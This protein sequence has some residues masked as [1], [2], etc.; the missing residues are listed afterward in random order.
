VS[1]T[2]TPR[3]LLIVALQ[4][5]HDGER[6]WTERGPKFRNL[7]GAELREF[8][9]ADLER[10][11]AQA[12]ELEAMLSSLDAVLAGDPN[13]WLR[14]ILDDADRDS[15][16]IVKGRLLDTALI[17]AFRKGKQAERVSYETAIVL[18]SELDLPVLAERLT[19]ICSQENM[20]DREL[21]RLLT[22]R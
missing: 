13:I 5:L 12:N 20:A 10:S 16:S 7:V 21:H 9:D 22:M 15:E 11:A 1:K 3:E 19:E 8:L 17:G 4:D 6:A 14:A 18:A 2:K